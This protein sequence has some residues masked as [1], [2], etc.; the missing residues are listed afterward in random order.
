[1]DFSKNTGKGVNR[2]SLALQN[3]PATASKKRRYTYPLTILVTFGI[4][5]KN[6]AVLLLLVLL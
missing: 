1:M 6:G 4:G 3:G 2:I 5:K